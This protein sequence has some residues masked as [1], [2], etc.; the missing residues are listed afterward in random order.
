MLNQLFLTNKLNNDLAKIRI[1]DYLSNEYKRLDGLDNNYQEDIKW[2][3][4]KIC[5]GFD[6]EYYN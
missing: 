6:D 3:Q 4:T 1:S 5:F 2:S